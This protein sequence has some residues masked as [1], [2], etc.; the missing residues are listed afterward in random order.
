[1]RSRRILFVSF[2]D[3]GGT[4]TLRGE[5]LSRGLRG[6]GWD[7]RLAVPNTARSMQIGQGLD[8][9]PFYFDSGD[10]RF[11]WD[12]RRLSRS[13]DPMFVHF[14]NPK[15][16]AA[17]MVMS[18]RRVRC[19]LDWEDWSTFWKKSSVVRAYEDLRSRFLIR[20]A[21]LVVTASRW[22]GDYI[23][24]GFGRESLYLPYA[25]LPRSFPNP[26]A[27]ISGDVLVGMGNLYSSWDHDLFVEAMGRLKGR[28]VTPK[29]RWIGDGEDMQRTRQ[30]VEALVLTR[31]ELPGYLDWD[32][33]L[34]ELREAYCLV[35]PIRRN[36]LNLARCP[37]KCFQFAQSGR[38]VITSDV[39]EVRSI[40]GDLATYVEPT[41]DGYAEGIEK[42]LSAGRQEDLKYDLTTQRWDLR[43]L[44]LSRALEGVS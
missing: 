44:D 30:R 36:P 37:F 8:V 29:A 26:R 28:G 14:L 15:E 6:L 43:A 38:P 17:A 12:L 39:G 10:L 21:A 13:F 24:D 7:A 16:K 2:G 33:M 9:E 32:L 41:A 3:L 31:F 18:L 27:G 40:L 1:M 42:C 22:L 23:R 20:R 25:C 19:V 11:Y 35:F 4:A 34:R 5:E